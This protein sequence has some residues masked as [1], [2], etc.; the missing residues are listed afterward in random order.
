MGKR[1]KHPKKDKEK[2]LIER[3]LLRLR[4]VEILT[5]IILSVISI[6]TAIIG[7]IVDLLK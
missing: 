7:M 1:K 6:L 4:R 5:S 2:E 3:Q